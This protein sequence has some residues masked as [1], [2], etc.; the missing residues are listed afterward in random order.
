MSAHDAAIAGFVPEGQAEVAHLARGLWEAQTDQ[1]RNQHPWRRTYLDGDVHSGTSRHR[2]TS[3]DALA[4]DEVSRPGHRTRPKTGRPE[5][6][7]RLVRGSAHDV[8][9]PDERGLASFDNIDRRPDR[10][11][12]ARRRYLPDDLV[13]GTGDVPQR[14]TCFSQR[15][16]RLDDGLG[17]EVG[18]WN[19]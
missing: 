16:R 5:R 6:G 13:A 7:L 14:E 12:G 18:H 15:E 3:G 10:R 1:P 9:H 11:G 19:R 2:R 8:G 4:E 17:G